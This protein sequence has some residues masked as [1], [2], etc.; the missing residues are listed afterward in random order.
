MTWPKFVLWFLL[1][2]WALNSL[3]PHFQSNRL[4][5]W[6]LNVGQGESVLLREPS[7]HFLLYDGGPDDSVLQQLGQIL[8]PWQRHIDLV[9][10]SHDHSDHVTGLIGVVQR[11]QIGEIW[12]S[13]AVYKGAEYKRFTTEVANH[14]ILKRTMQYHIDQCIQVLV[15]PIPIQFGRATLQIYHPLISM[16]NSD[17]RQPHD[18]T[19]SVKVSFNAESIFLTG[20]LNEQHEQDMLDGCLPPKCTLRATILQIPHHGSATGLLPAFLAAVAPKDALIPVGL[21]NRFGHPR[22]ET[23][24]KLQDSHIPYWRTDLNGRIYAVL[25]GSHITVQPEHPG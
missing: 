14:H 22:I 11:Y 19:L 24:S 5:I 15:C 9:I 12:T 10:L 20:D 6:M 7:G 1:F 2:I 21:H 3:V 18:A 4:E 8:P 13:G 25:G 17:P 16:Q 23:L